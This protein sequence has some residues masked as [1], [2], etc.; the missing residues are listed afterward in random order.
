[1]FQKRFEAFAEIQQPPPLS[2]S[3]FVQ[4]STFSK[5]SQTDLLASA[6]DCFKLS[7]TGV[8]TLLS[9]LPS[10]DPTSLSMTK[11]DLH[12]VAKICVGNSVYLQKF[13]QS[14]TRQSK[15]VQQNPSFDFDRIGEFFTIKVD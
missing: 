13:G 9:A 14:R 10:I 4:G 3:D 8:G 1:M 5:V 15:D 12:Q 2:Y 11:E 7:K 6:G